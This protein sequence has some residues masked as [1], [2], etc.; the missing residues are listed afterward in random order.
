MS[1]SGDVQTASG[2][3][4]RIEALRGRDG[5]AAR[6]RAAPGTLENLRRLRLK[7]VPSWLME[8]LRTELVAVLSNEVRKLEH[9]IQIHRQA[10]SR[11]S[12]DDLRAA[13]AQVSAARKLLE[14]P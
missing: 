5:T 14:R 1:A 3:L 13:E 2:L 9:E 4:N 10:G 11:H 12:D 7:T 6:L 8:R